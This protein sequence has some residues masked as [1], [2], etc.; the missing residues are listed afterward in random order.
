MRKASEGCLD[1]SGCGLDSRLGPSEALVVMVC[2]ARVANGV[3]RFAG[4]RNRNMRVPPFG[5]GRRPLH[6][7]CGDRSWLNRLLVA[8]GSHRSM[9]SSVVGII[10]T[11][12]T[13]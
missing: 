12:E 5:G 7:L 2:V 1:M 13:F 10:R 6:R 3:L 8:L 9:V 4:R 11:F